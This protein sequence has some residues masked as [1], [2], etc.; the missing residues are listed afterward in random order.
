MF[1]DPYKTHKY[2]CVGRTWTEVIP[3]YI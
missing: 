3:N 2:S 1:S